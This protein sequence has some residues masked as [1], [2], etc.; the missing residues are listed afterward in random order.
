[1]SCYENFFVVL[2]KAFEISELWIKSCKS[3]ECLTEIITDHLSLSLYI[4][5]TDLDIVLDTHLESR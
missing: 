1:M 2:F 3:E 5:L 4:L